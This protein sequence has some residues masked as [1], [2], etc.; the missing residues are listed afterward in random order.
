MNYNKMFKD[1]EMHIYT[2]NDRIYIDSEDLVKLLIDIS[3]SKSKMDIHTLTVVKRLVE[4]IKKTFKLLKASNQLDVNAPTHLIE[5]AR[6]KIKSLVNKTYELSTKKND[7]NSA[8]DPLDMDLRNLDSINL[9]KE[10][11]IK[12]MNDSFYAAINNFS[13]KLD[14]IE[15][16]I[17][18]HKDLI[19]EELKEPNKAIIKPKQDK[20][21]TKPKTKNNTANDAAHNQMDLE[22]LA[23]EIDDLT[24]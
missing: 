3:L 10:D 17:R 18:A 2:D 11:L 19:N 13:T 24:K 4:S 22:E 8:Y 20:P 16:S 15:A 12:I 6:T 7:V 5:L 9:T 21:T 1:A 23:N 14:S